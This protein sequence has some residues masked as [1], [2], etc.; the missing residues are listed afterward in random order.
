MKYLNMISTPPKSSSTSGVCKL[1][2]Y[3]T[4]QVSTDQKT[5]KNLWRE[6]LDLQAR[7]STPSKNMA[8]LVQ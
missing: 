2:S 3:S 7:Y 6:T 5:L 4:W 8:I 1:T